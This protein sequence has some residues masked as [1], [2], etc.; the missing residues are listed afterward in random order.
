V[1]AGLP[2]L[3]ATRIKEMDNHCWS[4]RIFKQ[5]LTQ[6][7][8]LQARGLHTQLLRVSACKFITVDSLRCRRIQNWVR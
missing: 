5:N 1:V 3:F 2:V 4:K 7:S 6:K 8:E